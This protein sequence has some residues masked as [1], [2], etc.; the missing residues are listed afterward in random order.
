MNGRISIEIADAD[1]TVGWVNGVVDRDNQAFNLQSDDPSVSGV[2]VT[3][4]K[5]TVLQ[6]SSYYTFDSES[7]LI[8][9]SCIKCYPTPLAVLSS[10]NQPVTGHIDLV[11]DNTTI[12]KSGNRLKLD[13]VSVDSIKSRQDLS[14]ERLTCLNNIIIDINGVRPDPK[15]G[16]ITIFAIAPLKIE[17]TPYGLK[18]TTDDFVPNDLCKPQNLPV[19]STSNDYKGYLAPEDPERN[20]LTTDKPEYKDWDERFD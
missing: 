2:V 1:G 3:G 15:T 18:V 5:E 13:V 10:G 19:L 9:P 16:E 11:S 4:S 8:E 12:E 17:T 7:A 14:S 20:V 6:M